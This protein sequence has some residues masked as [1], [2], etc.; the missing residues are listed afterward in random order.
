[1]FTQVQVSDEGH[2]A[3]ESSRPSASQIAS[4]HADGVPVA[5]NSPSAPLPTTPVPF[6]IADW[7]AERTAEDSSDENCSLETT[8]VEDE[9]EAFSPSD[10]IK[11]TL[12]SLHFNYDDYLSFDADP[13]ADPL[14]DAMPGGFGMEPMIKM[15]TQTPAHARQE[16]YDLV[17]GALEPLDVNK[18]STTSRCLPTLSSSQESFVNIRP[19]LGA[20]LEHSSPRVEAARE[21]SPA[22]TVAYV[23]PSHYLRNSGSSPLGTINAQMVI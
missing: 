3:L 17:D 18:L 20:S 9:T 22:I 21:C 13:L 2:Y 15:E 1:M 8:V 14:T 7:L 12:D 16:L 6:N 5:E 10:F 19:S 4:P 23:L 11:E